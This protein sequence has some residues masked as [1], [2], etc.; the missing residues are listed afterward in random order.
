METNQ[1]EKRHRT[2]SVFQETLPFP[3]DSPL[4]VRRQ[5]QP[6]RQKTNPQ[7][8]FEKTKKIQRLIRNLAKA[9]QT[10]GESEHFNQIK[11]ELKDL[12]SQNVFTMKQEISEHTRDVRSMVSSPDFKTVVSSDYNCKIVVWERNDDEPGQPFEKIQELIKH[13]LKVLCLDMSKDSRV[14]VSGSGDDHLIIWTRKNPGY[15]FK[16]F[17]ILKHKNRICSTALSNSKTTLVTGVDITCLI[18]VYSREKESDRF[19]LVHTIKHHTGR[20]TNLIL[21]DDSKTLVSSGKEGTLAAWSREETTGKYTLK[22]NLEKVHSKI[23]FSL[24]ISRDQKIVCSACFD[25]NIYFWELRSREEAAA[26]NS[27][28]LTRK[29][30][31]D[32]NGGVT[33]GVTLTPDFRTL[34]CVTVKGIL[35]YY[36][37]R[38]ESFRFSY[39]QRLVGYKG[40][41]Q[42]AVVHPEGNTF[43]SS[44]SSGQLIIWSRPKKSTQSKESLISQTLKD[45]SQA[46]RV[47]SVSQDSLT[48]LSLPIEGVPVAYARKSTQE[49]FRVLQRFDDHPIHPFPS[50]C[51]SK[52]S[53]VI[54]Y[55]G[56]INQILIFRRKKRGKEFKLSQVIPS[57]DGNIYAVDMTMKAE[58]VAVGVSGKVVALYKYN[59]ATDKYKAKR[60]L[61]AHSSHVISVKFSQDGL[62]LVSGSVDYNFMLWKREDTS[63]TNFKLFRGF[64]YHKAPVV[65]IDFSADTQMLVTSSESGRS[66][67]WRRS[68]LNLNFEPA[69]KFRFALTPG[70]EIGS[71]SLSNDGCTL[72]TAYNNQS[73]DI[74]KK[75]GQLFRQS[76]NLKCDAEVTFATQTDSDYFIA[77]KTGDI[78][79]IPKKNENL[80]SLFLNDYDYSALLYEALR[81]RSFKNSMSYLCHYLP[82]IASKDEVQDDHELMRMNSLVNPIYWF[83][84]FGYPDLLEDILKDYEYED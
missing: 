29:H 17:Q 32:L 12:V 64:S 39:K 27:Q 43:M 84:S 10:E 20:V 48:L 40:Y 80:F 21:T 63:K 78:E 13:K 54:V 28:M 33:L 77:S 30:T 25:G 79:I 26:Q 45:S 41:P 44:T 65:S 62:L 7:Q 3:T 82:R 46:I 60:K 70:S 67:V 47:L 31:I 76:K 55:G 22:Q 81:E 56:P 8:A 83:S 5:L 68:H 42:F 38:P 66:C 58:L 59:Q 23:V 71:V 2:E 50:G 57:K 19:K 34:I 75:D 1:K 37:D 11:D 9:K 6:P 73:V 14:L 4:S 53:K 49:K 18:S 36:R 15:L 52:N 35:V 69:Q 51:L 24:L 72:I 74:C 16:A 61:K